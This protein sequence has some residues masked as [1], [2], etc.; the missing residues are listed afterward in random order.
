MKKQT[1]VE[2]LLKQLLANGDIRWRGTSIFDLSEQ[3]KAMEKEQIKVAWLNSLTKGDYCS[4][5]EY[6]QS[7][8]GK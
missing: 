3:A 6:Y 8:Y 4:A 2:W 7:T 1:A 5:E